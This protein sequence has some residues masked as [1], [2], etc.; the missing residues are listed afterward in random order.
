[1]SFRT[2]DYNYDLPKELIAVRPAAARGQSRL[3]LL[4]RRGE[5]ISHHRFDELPEL[6][7]PDELLVLNNTK[8]IPA[9]IRFQSRNAEIFLLQQLDDF[10]WR[11]LVRPG[12]W[13]TVGRR[14][15]EPQFR[16]KVTAIFENGDRQIRFDDRLNLE[17]VGQMPLQPYIER[18]PEAVD[19]ER[20]QTVFASV[21]GAVAAPTA[22]LHFSQELLQRLPYEFVTLHVG[23]GTFKPVKTGL[24]TEHEMHAESFDIDPAA[25]QR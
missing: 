21:P 2:E 3:M 25:A 1:M 14:F 20:Y 17:Q 10:T 23:V 7:T 11:C 4:E 8:V 5:N 6:V 13:F 24:I 16:G 15:V 18:E 19:S 22:G 12:P 9:R